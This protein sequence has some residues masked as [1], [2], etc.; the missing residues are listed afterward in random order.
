MKKT[1]ITVQVF[2][3]LEEIESILKNQGYEMT[4]T[5]S[6]N[7]WYFSKLENIS[8]VKYLDLLNNSFIVRQVLTDKEEIKLVYKRKEVDEFNNVIAEEKIQSYVNSLQKTIDIFKACGLNN[9]CIVKN[10]TH[11]FKKGDI[12]FDIQVIEN[13]GIFIECEEFEA[14]K[15][16]SIKQK[17]EYLIKIVSSLNLKLGADYSC[18][19]VLMLIKKTNN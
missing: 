12:C 7:D 2:N 16:L 17:L 13:L 6:I 10:I 3:S 18:K 1:E 15:D 8:N 9:Y 11:S 19:K 5:Y 4:Q 14:I